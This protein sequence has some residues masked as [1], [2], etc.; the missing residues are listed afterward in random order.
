MCAS[1]R[2]VVKHKGAVRPNFAACTLLPY[3]RQGDLGPTLADASGEVWLN[4]PHCAK[5]CVLGGATCSRNGGRGPASGSPRNLWLEEERPCHG[6]SAD[7][8]EGNR[9]DASLRRPYSNL[10]AKKAVLDGRGTEVSR[11]E[12]SSAPAISPPTAPTLRIDLLHPSGIRIVM[13]NCEESLAAQAAFL[14]VRSCQ[15][16]T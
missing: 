14:P 15:C 2:M 13:G 5:F 6:G 8:R 9:A 16:V 11:R 4:H 1:S 3:D 7:K 12:T 10:E